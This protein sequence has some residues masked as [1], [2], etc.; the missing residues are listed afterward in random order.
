MTSYV[1]FRNIIINAIVGI[2]RATPELAAE[3][4]AQSETDVDLATLGID[5]MSIIDLCMDI[6]QKSGREV[7]IEELIENPT[8]NKLAKFLSEH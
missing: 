4:S 1:E 2:K 3:W 7:L 8:L 6:E 5:S